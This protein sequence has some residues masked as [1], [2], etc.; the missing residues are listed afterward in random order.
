M[1]A[2]LVVSSSK[3]ASA[4]L[5]YLGG[6]GVEGGQGSNDYN[7]GNSISC[8]AFCDP[9]LFLSSDD[10]VQLASQRCEG[11]IANKPLVYNSCE[12]Y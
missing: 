6:A 5:S 9:I 10:Y 2:L 8:L 12:L 7:Y 11:Y 3:N 4:S 1:F